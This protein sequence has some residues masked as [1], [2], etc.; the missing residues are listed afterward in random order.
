MSDISFA[1]QIGG[2][3]INPAEIKD[4]ELQEDIDYVV[5]AIFDQVGDLVCPEHKEAP[6]FLCT[7]NN[8][9]EIS[10]ETFGCCDDLIKEVKKRMKL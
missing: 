7:G 10:V 5:G 3:T 9:D 2:K 6:R 8:F 4:K 1:F